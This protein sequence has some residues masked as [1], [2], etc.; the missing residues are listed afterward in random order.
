M[1]ILPAFLNLF[2]VK[3]TIAKASF[4]DNVY[5]TDFLIL[6]IKLVVHS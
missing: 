6:M 4:S 3:K 5:T 2:G 1:F